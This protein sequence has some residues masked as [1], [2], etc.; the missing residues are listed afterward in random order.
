[1]L[2]AEEAIRNWASAGS[3]GSSFI[4]GWSWIGDL[5]DLRAEVV[6]LTGL[7]HEAGC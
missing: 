3:T 1:V 6:N 7:G 5:I 4:V 2:N